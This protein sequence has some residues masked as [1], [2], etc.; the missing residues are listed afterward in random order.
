[1]KS[2]NAVFVVLSIGLSIIQLS[3]W[4][5]A[6]EADV[7]TAD[8]AYD[9]V[10][11]AGAAHLYADPELTNPLSPRMLEYWDFAI[12]VKADENGKADRILVDGFDPWWVSTEEMRPV[13]RATEETEL[14]VPKLVKPDNGGETVE[15]MGI[16]DYL[17]PGEL[18]A[19][20]VQPISTMGGYLLVETEGS[21]SGFVLEETI[22][23]VGNPGME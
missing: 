11:V 19:L 18:V 20:S 16:L 8:P 3:G 13:Y 4:G 23:P 22:E 1:M 15:H 5:H 14:L 17:E 2:A 10:C 9:R 12:F 21:Q 7:D 6:E